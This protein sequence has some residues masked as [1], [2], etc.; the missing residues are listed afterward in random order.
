MADQAL[1]D[2]V[3]RAKAGVQSGGAQEQRLRSRLAGAGGGAVPLGGQMGI[4]PPGLPPGAD[5]GSRLPQMDPT[6]IMGV[7]KALM[8]GG[9]PGGAT[10]GITP[11]TPGGPPMTPPGV[12]PGTPPGGGV[13]GAL[14]R[15][16]MGVPPG[17]PQGGGAAPVPGV[18]TNPFQTGEVPPPPGNRGA[19]LRGIAGNEPRGLYG[20]ALNDAASLL[21]PRGVINQPGGAASAASGEPPV[22]AAKVVGR[23][24]PPSGS[25]EAAAGKQ[26]DETSAFEKAQKSYPGG[27]SSYTVKQGDTLTSIAKQLGT[28][29]DALASANGLRNANRIQYG[30]TLIVPGVVA[31]AGVGRTKKKSGLAPFAQKGYKTP[32]PTPRPNR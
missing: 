27:K 19:D 10:R 15:P 8:G 5:P 23:T 18:P 17:P 29:V 6:A 24:P 12:P 16:P 4:P 30:R 7:I 20:A 21:G 2:L 14:P 31:G 9:A 3:A 11:P 1:Q 32:K 28:T 22:V 26:A 25:V 13:P